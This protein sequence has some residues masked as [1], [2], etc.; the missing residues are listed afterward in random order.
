MPIFDDVD[1]TMRT[2]GW[3]I[4]ADEAVRRG[5]CAA[6]AIQRRATG[7]LPSTTTQ[8]TLALNTAEAA[9]CRYAASE[10]VA[11]GEMP[12]TFP[13]TGGS[14]TPSSSPDCT[15]SRPTPTRS[16]ARI[17]PPTPTRDDFLI[18][19]YIDSADVTPPVIS[20]VQVVDLTPYTAEVTW[21]TDEP[22]TSQVEYGGRQLWP[23]HAD[24]Y[25]PGHAH[26]ACCAAW[27]RL[28]PITSGCARSTSATTRPSPAIW[29]SPRR[30]WAPVLRESSHPQASDSNPGTQ[31]LPWLTIQHAA[32]VAQPGDTIIVQP[33]NYGRTVIAHGGAAG[34]YITFKGAAVPDTKSGGLG[35]LLRPGSS[36]ADSR[37]P[38]AQ[39]RHPGL[40]PRSALPH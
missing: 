28:P 22:A 10:G 20:A 30:L 36:R 14:P 19:F 34:Q 8:V 26:S 3:D 29:S 16:N 33:G 6:D 23:V 21:T 7:E 24:R 11:Y 32:D 15:T 1:G 35:R 9:T 5:Q 2:G 40:R 18:S 4:G 12:H 39:R 27:T 38:G 25:R 31:A 17:A 37:Q 13:T